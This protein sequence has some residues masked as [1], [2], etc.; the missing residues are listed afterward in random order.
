MEF[1]REF[2]DDAACLEWLWH[3]RY[4]EDGSH[5]FCL[6]C[7]KERKCPQ[8]PRT[9]GVGLR[10]LRTPHAPAGRD[11]L[12]QV[13]DLTGPVPGEGISVMHVTHAI[14]AQ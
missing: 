8:G 4:S 11:D 6:K 3:N 7:D 9:S 10:L 2:P 13:L 12:R 14:I 5:A 1:M